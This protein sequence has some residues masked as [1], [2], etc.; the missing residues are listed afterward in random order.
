MYA[1]TVGGFATGATL[2][3]SATGAALNVLADVQIGTTSEDDDI[4]CTLSDGGNQLDAS[5]ISVGAGESS[6]IVLQGSDSSTTGTITMT[7]HGSTSGTVFNEFHIQALE[8][9]NP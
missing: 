2:P 6:Q 4:G 5:Q 9:K 7:C 1:V 3:V 8:V